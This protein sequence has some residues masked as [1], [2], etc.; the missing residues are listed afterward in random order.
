[1]KVEVIHRSDK[2][3]ENCDY[4]DAMEIHIDG[5]RVFSVS[6][7][8]PEDASLSRDFNDA[9]SVPDLLQRAYEAGKNGEPFEMSTVDSD[10]I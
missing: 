6:D 3:V 5:K 10:E 9:Y 8:E 4:R 7:G 1:M 2:E